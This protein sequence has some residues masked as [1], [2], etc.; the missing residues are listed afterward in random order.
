M[1]A[2]GWLV[3]LA[4]AACGSS[5]DTPPDDDGGDDDTS[6]CAT[7]PALCPQPVCG[8]GKVES[9]EACDDG[10]SVTDPCAYGLVS[11]NV[12]GQTCQRVAGTVSYC[13]DGVT[14]HAEACDDGNTLTE[15]CAYGATS[16]S[17][18][19]GQCQNGPG[20]PSFC[21]DGTLDEADG[22]ACDDGLPLT[23]ACAYGLVSCSVCGASCQPIAGTPTYCGD[24]LR[25]AQEQ[26]ETAIDCDELGPQ[27]AAG[28]ATCLACAQSLAGCTATAV[29]PFGTLDGSAGVGTSTFALGDLD[30]DGDVDGVGQQGGT[31]ATWE[32][33][34]GSLTLHLT[35]LVNVYGSLSRAAIAD[36]DGDGDADVA[37]LR[38]S[39]LEWL[40]NDAGT[41][42][43]H[44]IASALVGSVS[45]VAADLD[46]DDDADIVTHDSSGQLRLYESSSGQFGPN[47][48]LLIAGVDVYNATTPTHSL[49]TADFDGDGDVDLLSGSTADAASGVN[50]KGIS[51]YENDGDAGFTERAIAT[52][53]YSSFSDTNSA[54]SVRTGDMDGDDDVDV[55]FASRTYYAS[56]LQ[57]YANDGDGSFTVRSFGAA[58]DTGAW[59][60]DMADFDLDGDSDVLLVRN[61]FNAAASTDIRAVEWR[62]NTNGVGTAW[63]NHP[64]AV[65]HDSRTRAYAAP[66]DADLD[67]DVVCQS[68]PGGGTSW[69]ANQVVCPE[70]FGGAGC[71]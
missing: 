43:R 51:W 9:G 17:V 50:R 63:T 64:L 66:V 53:V 14:T 47:G 38:E 35:S 31:F 13:G 45:V 39:V 8:N 49:A 27:F 46:G 22:E 36:V 6:T 41:F 40:E 10:N 48:V 60:T 16:C 37:V 56:V 52:A 71:F 24:G 70:G 67:V 28:V 12:C 4:C 3:L 59:W 32:N 57:W 42:T 18:C 44:V 19:D 1:R 11:C 5:S 25:Q 33:R 68:S 29:D 55:V 30:G 21:G 34:A 23:T 20:V 69:Y 58:T 65:N 62:E 2:A 54:W 15:T 26:C 61:L 7:N